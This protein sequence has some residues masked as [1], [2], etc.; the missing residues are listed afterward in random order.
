M[1]LADIINQKKEVKLQLQ[2][3]EEKGHALSDYGKCTYKL[4]DSIAEYLINNIPSISS[5]P[6]KQSIPEGYISIQ[7]FERK[8]GIATANGLAQ[9]CRNQEMPFNAYTIDPEN[10]KDNKNYWYVHPKRTFDFLLTKK[11]FQNKVRR[12]CYKPE[13]KELID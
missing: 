1:S 8:F 9:Y 3:C 12:G 10:S 6:Q 4:L 11:V 2:L 7:E 5:K 13:L